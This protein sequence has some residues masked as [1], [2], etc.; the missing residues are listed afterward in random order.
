MHRSAEVVVITGASAGVGRATALAFA[1]RGSHIGLVARGRERLEDTRRAVEQA[2]GRAI[3]VPADTADAEQVETAAVETER[4]FGPI[5]VWVNNAMVSVFA[6]VMQISPAEFR[7]VME[8]TFL[9]YVYGTQAALRRMLPRN[10]GAIVQVGSALA[11]RGIPLQA[12]YCAAKHAIQGFCDSL[13]SELIHERSRI[14][15]TMVQ[16]PALNTPQFEWVRNKLAHR[17]QPVP[18]IYQPEVAAEAII[19]AARHGGREVWVGASVVAA[20]VGDRL[21]PGLLDRLLAS[22]GFDG[23]LTREPEDPERPDNLWAPA[24][25][26]Y[27]EHG[28]IR[29]SGSAP[30]HAVLADPAQGS[31]CCC[32]R[33]GNRRGSRPAT[34]RPER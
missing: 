3:V 17:P 11:Y 14:R 25:G 31:D 18:P 27:R 6:P 7:R 30:Q 10:A 21:M 15:L 1:R 2:G 34:S 23:Q 22:R 16:M 33:T 5:D 20:I 32:G 12:P 29:S 24:P 19:W 26:S 28:P 4:A 9:G 13:Q 8:V